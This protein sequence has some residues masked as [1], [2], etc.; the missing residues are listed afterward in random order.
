M[1]KQQIV[2]IVFAIHDAQDSQENSSESIFT[3]ECVLSF[4][5]VGKN[6]I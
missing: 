2:D 5:Y 1:K 4:I 3:A 6:L